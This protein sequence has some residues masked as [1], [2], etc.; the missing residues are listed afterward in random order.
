MDLSAEGLSVAENEPRRWIVVS[1]PG[2]V[3]D[4]ASRE[5]ASETDEAH[6]FVGEYA[7]AQMIVALKARGLQAHALNLDERGTPTEL[8][9]IASQDER[10]EISFQIRNIT[11][12]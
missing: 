5:M 4:P 3:A 8:Q 12:S 1:G 11:D 10:G 6:V 7:A 2:I 9:L